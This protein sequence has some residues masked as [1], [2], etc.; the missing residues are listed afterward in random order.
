MVLTVTPISLAIGGAPC[1]RPRRIAVPTF[2]GW[3]TAFITPINMSMQGVAAH[4]VSQ[5]AKSNRLLLLLLMA[6]TLS[7]CRMLIG[8]CFQLSRTCLL[9]ACMDASV[10][11]G[12]G[13]TVSSVR[14][15][16]RNTGS[17]GEQRSL[18]LEG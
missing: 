10:T 18:L 9:H 6:K 11:K 12:P 17:N 7:P 13:L 16:L 2:G 15:L 4:V 14:L 1:S 3:S 5:R 8:D